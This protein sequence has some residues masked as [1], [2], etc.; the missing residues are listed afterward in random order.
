MAQ[1]PG[2]PLPTPAPIQQAPPWA[3]NYL[4]FPAEGRRKREKRR[5]VRGCCWPCSP[6]R[7]PSLPDRKL[8][9]GPSQLQGCPPAPHPGPVES[10]STQ[11]QAWPCGSAPTPQLR[12]PGPGKTQ[13]CSGSQALPPG[14]RPRPGSPTLATRGLLG[15]KWLGREDDRSAPLASDSESLGQRDSGVKE[16]LFWAA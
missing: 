7:A 14:P 3:H 5:G 1:P 8:A 4:A 13:R 10:H 9:P 2:S 11:R 12:P 16:P 15:S 6:L